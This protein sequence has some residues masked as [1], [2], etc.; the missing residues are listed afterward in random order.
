M[1][2]CSELLR[3]CVDS[4]SWRY[5]REQFLGEPRGKTFGFLNRILLSLS[6]VHWVVLLQALF[7]DHASL[8]Q[9]G[10]G[11]TLNVGSFIGWATV[12]ATNSLVVNNG[13]SL[14]FASGWFAAL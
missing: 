3:M 9:R 5:Y 8:V 13:S 1:V 2:E 10:T 14:S 11:N 7:A 4:V 12:F 6:L